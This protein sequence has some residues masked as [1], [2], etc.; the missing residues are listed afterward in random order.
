[1]AYLPKYLGPPF[2]IQID[3]ND[4]DTI[5]ERTSN[6]YP[7]HNL[8]RQLRWKINFEGHP[9]HYSV[10]FRDRALDVEY[11]LNL[12][13]V[14]FW[15]EDA[16]NRPPILGFFEKWWAWRMFTGGYIKEVGIEGDDVTVY[17]DPRTNYVNHIDKRTV[18]WNSIHGTPA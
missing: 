14:L 13:D 10:W 12:L 3:N 4:I 15:C 2:S 16:N 1:M 9:T 11:K 7:T 18:K 5:T 6:L 17:F 8:V